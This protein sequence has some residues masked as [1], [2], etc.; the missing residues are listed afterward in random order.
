[1]GKPLNLQSY[2]ADH[3]CRKSTSVLLL[4]Y[5]VVFIAPFSEK[6]ATG[7]ATVWAE[8]TILTNKK[9]ICLI[10]TGGGEIIILFLEII[11]RTSQ[12]FNAT[13]VFYVK[14]VLSTAFDTFCIF[15]VIK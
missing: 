15:H 7:T 3:F 2:Q 9:C 14:N 1:M 13:S 12:M 4:P 11:I 8:E 10:S 6:V 5:N